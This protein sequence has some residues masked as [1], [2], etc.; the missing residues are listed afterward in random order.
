[1]YLLV[2]SLYDPCCVRLQDVLTASGHAV[3]LFAN[4][5]NDPLRFSWHLDNERCSSELVLTDGQRVTDTDIEGVVVR[6][7]GWVDPSGW[8]PS[9]LAYMQA[10]TQAA[11]LA[12]LWSLKC[13]VLNRYP[14]ALWYRPQLPLV[15]WHA[16]L[17][18][19]GLP[20]S[21]ILLTNIEEEARA[22][23]ASAESAG[24]GGAVYA[25][26]TS[27]AQYLV[28]SDD[29]WRGL[30]ALQ[31]R[32]PVCLTLPHADTCLGCVVGD[33]VIWNS[34]PPADA[35]MLE[36]ALRQLA[37]AA[38]LE[39]LEIALAHTEEGLRVVGVEHHPNLDR[40]DDAAQT[41]I[42]EAL[43]GTLTGRPT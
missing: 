11:L 25:P 37:A 10:E 15:A 1:M 28:S 32:A 24:V 13:P 7:A 35:K 22:F 38:G 18:R 33:R 40:F 41:E 30:A 2:G 3:G 8:T 27:N 31:S 29:D 43:V 6:S 20:A 16:L 17:W 21:H 26:L 4:P 9:D 23:R 12:W 42:V 14:A 36:P 5:L 39:F 19:V 34:S